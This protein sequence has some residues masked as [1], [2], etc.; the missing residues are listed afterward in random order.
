[1]MRGFLLSVLF[2]CFIAGPDAADGRPKVGVALGGGAAKGL[3]HIGVLKVLEEAGVP[4]DCITG[5]SM[6]S[7]VGGLYAVG[8][9][10]SELETIALEADWAELFSDREGRRVL[11]MEQKPWDSRHLATLPMRGVMPRA[12]SGLIEGGNVVRLFSQLSLPRQRTGD[13]RQF[14]IRFACVATD[15]MTGQAV[16]LDRGFLAE[17]IR[18]S[19]AIPTVFSP[20][21]IDGRL[22]VDGGLVRLLPAEDVKNLGADIVIGVDVGKREYTADELTSFIA[23]SNQT[24]NLMLDPALEEQH[25][26][27]DI[28]VQPDMEG[29]SLADFRNAR[30][31][32][33]RGEEAARAVFPRLRALADSLS[34]PSSDGGPGEL[35]AAPMDSVY[36]TKLSVEGLSDVPRRVVEKEIGIDLPERVSLRRLGKAID[37]IHGT[38]FFERVNSRIDME[39]TRAHLVYEVHE[40][41]GNELGVGLRYDTRRDASLLV[42]AAFRNVGLGGATITVDAIL[43]DEFGLEAK[44]LFPVG[45]ARS[46]GVKMR[47]VAAK[48]YLNLY[49]DAGRRTTY[50]AKDYFGEL[51]LGTLFS[52]RMA[53]AAGV[54]AEYVDQDLGAGPTGAAGRG[55]AVFPCFGTIVVDTYDRTVYPRRG[56][57]ARVSAEAAD[58]ALW[59][60]ATFVRVCF[61]WR[62]V[63]QIAPR[64]SILQNLYLGR[65]S[66]GHFP[67]AYYFFLGGVDER[68]TLLGRDGSFFGL[69][70]QERSGRHVQMAGLGVQWEALKEIFVTL[71]WNAGNTF[72]D[73]N[74]KLEGKR[75]INGG[76]LSLGADTVLGPVDL[77]I[78]TSEENDF[79]AYF[80]AGYKF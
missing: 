49:D 52:T 62:A 42:N 65:T 37:R 15:I 59:S 8:Y 38:R 12:P 18:A 73:W 61:D 51:T 34:A 36:V 54:R 40:K 27:C 64:V 46:F 68:I 28:L 55:D 33:Q 9:T 30:R 19:M 76:G 14:P 45:L 23:I 25:R 71:M 67:P 24:L 56:V 39:G 35:R 20:I 10:A 79:L 70:H 78:M 13:F 17:A 47:G 6:G 60:D 41:K 44:F 11:H 43:R 4:I 1:M 50:R 66:G 69:E 2:A 77:T 80:S 63:I 72:D 32:I 57:F 21:E 48:A 74:E 22:L 58:D 16:I 75:Y 31:I 3:A 7:V 26:L 5:V 29:V 53:V